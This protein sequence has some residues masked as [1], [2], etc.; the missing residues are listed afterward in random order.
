MFIHQ[1]FH[2]ALAAIFVIVTPTGFWDTSKRNQS[3]QSRGVRK[4][5]M[6]DYKVVP[7]LLLKLKNV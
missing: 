7:V 3:D 1:D 4:F 6:A 5:K 2:F